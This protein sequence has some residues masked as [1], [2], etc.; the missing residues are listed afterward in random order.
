VFSYRLDQVAAVTIDVRK[1]KA[2]RLV[3]GKCKKRKRKNAKKKKCD[4]TAHKLFRKG[5]S[6]KNSVPYSGRVKG[7]A[8][9]VGK[10][11]AVFTATAEGGK[12]RSAS[13]G[14][15]IVRP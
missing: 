8:L 11:K 14:F 9:K 4:L 3:K 2:G 13:V 12:S 6:G 7:K 5:K 1:V 15:R 10:Y